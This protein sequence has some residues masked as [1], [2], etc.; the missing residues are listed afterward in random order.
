MVN[1]HSELQFIRTFLSDTYM[2]GEIG[3]SLT[4]L[5]V[6]MDAVNRIPTDGSS[7]I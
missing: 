4:T 1:V 7:I 3:Y 2:N 6:A 5:E